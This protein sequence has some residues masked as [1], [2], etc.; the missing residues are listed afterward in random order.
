MWQEVYYEH[1]SENMTGNYWEEEKHLPYMVLERDKT[2]REEFKEH[3][4]EIG[5]KCCAW[6]DEYPGIL[7]NT[8]FMRFAMIHRPCNFSHLDNKNYS[9]N[10]FKEKIL[11][12]L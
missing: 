10:E 1:Y 11:S 3:L 9:I 4:I 6:N 5:F 2:R 7:V 12:E 8:K